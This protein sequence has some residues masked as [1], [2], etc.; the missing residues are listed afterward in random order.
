MQQQLHEFWLETPIAIG[1]TWRDMETPE[2]MLASYML[3]YIK[4]I[5]N[6]RTSIKKIWQK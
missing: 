5:Q 6:L 4:Q 2:Q 1:K 3:G